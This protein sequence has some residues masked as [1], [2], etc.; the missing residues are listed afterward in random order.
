MELT[1]RQIITQP[2]LLLDI[3]VVDIMMFGVCV[4]AFIM[5]VLAIIQM[6][7]NL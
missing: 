3:G 1:V 7:K 5:C 2:S 4:I 6:F